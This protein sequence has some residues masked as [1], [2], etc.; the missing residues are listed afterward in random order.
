MLV[1]AAMPAAAQLAATPGAATVRFPLGV[2]FEI[3]HGWSV[4]DLQ[5]GP[6]S[7]SVVVSRDADRPRESRSTGWISSVGGSSSVRSRNELSVVFNGGIPEPLSEQALKGWTRIDADRSQ[8]LSNGAVARWKIGRMWNVHEALA[9]GATLGATTLGFMKT[10]A[11][12]R[13]FDPAVLETALLTIAGSMRAM[14]RGLA[15]FHPALQM[16]LEWHDPKRWSGEITEYDFRLRCKICGQGSRTHM[17]IARMTTVTYEDLDDVLAL[18]TRAQVRAHKLDLG[19]VRRHAFADVAHS[20]SKTGVN[21]L[22]AWTEQPGSRAPFV[23]AVQ[24]G[25]GYF[26]VSIAAPEG[27]TAG[28]DELRN[29]FLTMA[30]SVRAWDGQ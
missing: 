11:P 20:P 17:V 16:A 26:F 18:V 25:T 29:D 21:A 3:P 4:R 2:Q 28:N 7:N 15:L 6:G 1:A 22:V 13:Q 30:G 27:V 9:G 10:D 14:P 8:V 5:F 23:G 19:E 12:A 24:R